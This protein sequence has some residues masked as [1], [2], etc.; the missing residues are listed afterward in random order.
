MVEVTDRILHQASVPRCVSGFHQVEQTPHLYY[1]SRCFRRVPQPPYLFRAELQLNVSL[2]KCIKFSDVFEEL[3]G[4]HVML[5]LGGVLELRPHVR[6]AADVVD[7]QHLV[8]KVHVHVVAVR[9][10]GAEFTAFKYSLECL[11]PARAVLVAVNRHPRQPVDKAP[12]IPLAEL[13][14]HF[15]A[16]PRLAAVHDGV[17]LQA[18]VFQV[19]YDAIE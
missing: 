6:H 5:Y 10:E 12:Y 1:Y 16:A 2:F 18:V 15:H 17:F 8:V 11:A 14:R 7:V 4:A 19:F 3:S 13:A 9:L